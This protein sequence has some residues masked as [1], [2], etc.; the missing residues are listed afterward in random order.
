MVS[1]HLEIKK[2]YYYVVLSYVDINGKRHRPWISTGLPEKGNKRKA[3]T[4]LIRIRGTYEPPTEVEELNSDMPFADY[5]LQ[6]LDIVKGACKDRHI[7]FIRRN[8]EK[9]NRALFSQE[10]LHLAR[11]GSTAHPAVLFRKAEN[12]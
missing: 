4:E 9:R 6:W 3:E 7:R 2:G 11:I 12:R 8:G 10:R 5:L 1:G